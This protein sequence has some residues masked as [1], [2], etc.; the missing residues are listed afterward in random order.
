[1]TTDISTVVPTGRPPRAPREGSD[2]L[3]RLLSIKT[4]VLLIVV[5]VIGYLTLTP[6][7]YLLYGTFVDTKTGVFSFDAFSRAYTDPGF[8]QMVGNSIVFAIGSAVVAFVIGTFLAY[9]MVRT[10]VPFKSLLFAAAMVPLIVPGIL[11]TI[12][13]IMLGS[14]RIGLLNQLPEALTGARPFNIFSMEGMMW[15]EGTHSAPVV[16]LFMVAAF[17][18]MDPSLEES[19]MISG[20]SRWTIMRRVTLPL[21]R[22]AIAGALLIMV[23]RALES[24]EVPA[25]LG[26]PTNIQVFTSQI[27]SALRQYPTDRGGAGA[28]SL[29]L[30]AIAI[31]GVWVVN[32]VG[33]KEAATGTVT[34]KGFRPRPMPLGKWRI[35]VGLVVVVYFVVIVI[36]PVAVMAY[37]SLLPHYTKFSFDL[38]SQMNFDNYVALFDKRIFLRS[39]LNSLAL[40]AGCS[41]IVM[42]LSSIASWLV[43]RTRIPGRQIVDQLTF[44]PLVIPGLVLGLSISFVYLRNPLPIPVYGT[45]LILLI[46]YCTRFIPYGMR[47]AVS[48]IEQI[49][50]ELEESAQVAGASWWQSFRRVVLPL[51]A[52]GLLA[53]WVYIFVISVRELSSSI[54]LYSP[55]NEVVSI[56]TFEFYENG[57]LTAVS[58]L[59]VLMIGSLVIIVSIAYK[60]GA[61]VGIR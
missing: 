33:G 20:A 15:V 47:Y 45:L 12:A 24:F 10:D 61:K 26:L 51:M 59:G 53:G 52:P 58:A 38:F 19:A 8:V 17:R 34:G 6:V 21:V 30:L 41:T 57:D 42:A 54:L 1:M 2:W 35:W 43:T 5:V 25:L 37:T 40:A 32:R 18:S 60:L 9:V 28:L 29:L 14:N 11:Y 7:L 27:F 49:A 36:L 13:W 39:V 48:S 31:V 22:P 4:L 16:F 3:S 23:V 46:A 56:L 44:L 50:G 55:G